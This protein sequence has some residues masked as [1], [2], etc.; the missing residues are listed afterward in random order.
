MIDIIF[1]TPADIQKQGIPSLKLL[2]DEI[3]SMR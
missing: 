1:I 3:E 2:S